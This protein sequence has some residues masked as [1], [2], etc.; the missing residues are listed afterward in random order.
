[1]ISII[2]LNEGGV[3]WKQFLSEYVT[4]QGAQS[5]LKS[6]TAVGRDTV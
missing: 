6:V 4:N 5:L 1:M 3:Y 2:N